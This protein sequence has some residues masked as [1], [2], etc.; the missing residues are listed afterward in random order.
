MRRLA[1]RVALV[2]VAA[3]W[4]AVA[5]A[6]GGRRRADDHLPAR[7]LAAHRRGHDVRRVV[8]VGCWS[9]LEVDLR[10]GG[11]VLGGHRYDPVFANTQTGALFATTMQGL[12]VM[13]DGC[14]FSPTS[15]AAGRCDGPKSDPCY[16]NVFLS[17]VVA[18]SGSAIYATASSPYDSRIYRSDDDGRAFRVLSNVGPP[19]EYW[20]SFVIAPSNPNR[21]YLSGYRFTTQC[22]AH[23]TNVGSA[24]LNANCTGSGTG[25]AMPKCTTVK[26]LSMF[27]SDDSG[28]TWSPMSLANLVVSQNSA[29]S[30]VG[31]DPTDANQVY[32]H[33]TN[34]SGAGGD[35][36]Y[37]SA[38]GGGLG[39]GDPTAWTKVFETNDPRGLVML[40][41]ANGG[42]VAAAQASGTFSSA[43]GSGMRRSNVVQLD[44][45]AERTAHQLPGRATRQQGHLGVHSELR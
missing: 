6:N 32:I 35:G 22:D 24:C 4:C 10:G 17:N 28:A 15:V 45:A 11:P 18:G 25:S 23:S 30:V 31:V 12:K 20:Q 43:G 41:R 33:V 29:I 14:T 3:A 2:C 44:A 7:Q 37:K 9:Y 26:V 19:D 13:R 38:N 34:A 21:I 1:L 8:L 27:R 42:L 5:D 16:A 39:S 36:V 40:V